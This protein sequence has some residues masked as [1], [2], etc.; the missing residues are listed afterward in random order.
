LFGDDRVGTIIA[1]II[2]TD[3]GTV[4]IKL[5][6]IMKAVNEMKPTKPVLF[7]GFDEGAPTCRANGSINC[8]LT[9]FP[10]FL[11][12]SGRCAP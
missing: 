2:Q 4:A 5:P 9:A 1:G 3:P 8:A 7:A 11:P 12:L 10:I 6:P